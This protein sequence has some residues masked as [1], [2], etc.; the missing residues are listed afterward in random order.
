VYSA[1]VQEADDYFH[2]LRREL[3][4]TFLE[5]VILIERQQVTL[6]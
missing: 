3:Q 4:E 1:P 5:G 6:I 2:A